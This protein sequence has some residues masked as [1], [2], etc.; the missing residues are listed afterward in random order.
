MS[1]SHFF[2][3]FVFSLSSRMER[4]VFT[5]HQFALIICIMRLYKTM[6]NS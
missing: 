1:L 6:T 2:F 5:M 4:Q 3:V